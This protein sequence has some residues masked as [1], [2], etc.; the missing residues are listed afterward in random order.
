MNKWYRL[1]RY[2]W[3]LHFMLLFS[4]WLP[5]N[6]VFLRMRGFLC[7]FFFQRCGRNL[8]LGRNNVFYNPSGFVI[9][10]DVYIGYNNWMCAGE[11][12]TIGNEVMIGPHNVIVSASHTMERGSFRFAPQSMSPI[13]IGAGSWIS[14]HCVISSGSNV[15]NGCLIAANSVV[16][17]TL[18]AFGQYAGSPAVRVKDLS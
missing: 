10:D 17:G 12:I 1:L 5:D 16:R 9:G 4:N 2:D 18:D 3:P 14:S 7:S 6:V 15:G 8:R 13:S 11:L